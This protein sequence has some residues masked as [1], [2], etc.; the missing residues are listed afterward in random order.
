M[1][2]GLQTQPRR[3]RPQLLLMQ[4]LLPACCQQSLQPHRSGACCTPPKRHQMP[5]L[6]TPRPRRPASAAVGQLGWAEAAGV[7][8]LLP[9]L[10]QAACSCSCC[11]ASA[12]VP[13]PCWL[14]QRQHQLPHLLQGS[15][16]RCCLLLAVP[17]SRR[18]RQLPGCC[19]HHHQPPQPD[20]LPPAAAAAAAPA[21]APS[22]AC[23]PCRLLHCWAASQLQYQ[24]LLLRAP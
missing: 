1:V 2:S 4:G 21:A 5:L 8:P 13:K 15:V 24:H 7:L 14:Q 22:S 10:L 12:Q 11:P 23:P 20:H 18:R 3:C 6:P 16:A 17:S 19:H 9:A